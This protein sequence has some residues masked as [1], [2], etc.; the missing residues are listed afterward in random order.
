[1]IARLQSIAPDDHHVDLT[2]LI[3]VVFILLIFFVVTA[4]F[5]KEYGVDATV[6]PDN[7]TINSDDDTLTIRI[8]MNDRFYLNGTAVDGAALPARVFAYL[9]IKPEAK[10]AV[11]AAPQSSTQAL[12]IAVDAVRQS[13]VITVPIQRDRSG[14]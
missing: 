3:D 5:I 2:P 11:L 8:S 6:P 9:A 12:V 14:S 1:M 10:V 4:T 7:S 13:G